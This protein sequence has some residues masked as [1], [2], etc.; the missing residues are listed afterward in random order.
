MRPAWPS[1][2]ERRR[3]AVISPAAAVRRLGA[4]GGGVV[5]LAVASFLVAAAAGCGGDDAS[6]PSATIPESGLLVG[7]G[8]SEAWTILSV[9]R[10]G[11]RATLHELRGG[12][13]TVWTSG[14][15]LPATER[16]HRL[17]DFTVLLRTPEGRLVRF[18]PG[19]E[20]LSEATRVAS[21]A[22]G[23]VQGRY[24]AWVHRA[25][26]RVWEMGTE[27]SWTYSL[28]DSVLWAGLGEDGD[29]LA[30]VASGDST[31][32]LRYERGTDEPADGRR[33]GL[34][35]PAVVT[36]WGKL[37]A[38]AEGGRAIR[39]LDTSEPG[40]E[41]RVELD[42]P[43]TALAAS[44][45]SHQLYVGVGGEDPHLLVVN[46]F[47]LQPER[48]QRFRRQVEEIRT[49]SLGGPPLVR[50]ADGIFLAPWG[51][52]APV[53]V[54]VTWRHDLPLTLPGGEVMGERGGRV[55]R[56]DP[57]G[58]GEGTE[59]GPAD[60]WWI[61]LRWRPPRTLAGEQ[62]AEGRSPAIGA[63]PSADSAVGAMAGVP[64]DTA[65]GDGAG[66]DGRRSASRGRP[67]VDSAARAG[68]G[69]VPAA[70]DGPEAGFYAV[71]VAARRRDGVVRLTDELARA[72]Y[73]TAIQRHRD[74]AGRVWHR[75]LVGPYPD[76]DRVERIGRELQRERD[77][78][79][80]IKELGPGTGDRR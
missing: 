71:V 74:D 36:A 51:E 23:T 8:A 53:P 24:G 63:A 20:R 62:V 38:A 27:G 80:W 4:R 31:S 59:L 12:G 10:T 26:G 46:R 75:G 69:A 67:A 32:L 54:D 21:T 1:G 37:L 5:L 64:G 68:A 77:L 65:T 3:P 55:V 79:V 61:P 33:A 17:G 19:S 72:G 28:R 57:G 70:G 41:G 6:G 42:G 58:V 66:A 22:D 44:P 7:D 30:L 78:S 60:R 35:T 29:L 16:V 40:V 18:D 50:T 45:S 34:G 73:P 2:T 39:V 9:P 43:V 76:R 25:T 14:R 15:S 13:D 49:S 52:G 56:F 11:G 47:S 48:R